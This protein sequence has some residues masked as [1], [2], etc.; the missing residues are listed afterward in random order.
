[1]SGLHLLIG[2]KKH[3][4]H[5]G[6][7]KLDCSY[8]PVRHQKYGRLLTLDNLRSWLRIRKG[9]HSTCRVLLSGARLEQFKQICFCVKVWCEK[10][11]GQ[12]F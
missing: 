6:Q 4:P 11:P 1:M 10:A 9:R 2:W 12:H 5:S 8:P 7:K 3:L